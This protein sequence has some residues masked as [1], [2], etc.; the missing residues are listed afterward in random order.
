MEIMNRK[1]F[2]FLLIIGASC[3]DPYI[4]NL[5][6]IKP[7]LVVEGLITNENNSY[8]IKLSRTS[9]QRDSDPD[10]VADAAV[11]IIDEA[12]VKTNL[13]NCSDGYYKTDSTSFIGVIGKRYVL[14]IFTSDNKEYKSEE[15]TLYPVAKIDTLYYEKAEEAIGT[16]DLYSGIK[17]L[18]KSSDS[19][20]INNYF[21]WTFEE[22]WKTIMPGASRYT[23]ARINDTTFTFKAIPSGNEIC[24]KKN[25]SSSILVN[26][27]ISSGSKNIDRQ[28]IQ[29]IAPDLS[30]KLTQQYS[31][32]VKQYS[33]SEKEYNFWNNL[34]KVSE[35]NGDIFGS[36]PFAVTSNIYNVNDRSEM[37]FGYFEVLAVNQRR[38]NISAHDLDSLFLPQYRSN[39]VNVVISPSD[40]TG[41]IKPTWDG[42]YYMWMDTRLYTFIGP[43]VNDG[44]ILEGSVYQHDLIKFVFS[45]NACSICK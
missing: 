36:Q 5:K 4:P 9:R 2:F 45:R 27:I 30:D 44:V 43:I 8:K 35:T 26:S 24:W 38:L 42:L 13:Q 15:C 29:F 22:S 14:Q 19:N 23:Y 18:L 39:C 7:L 31:I 17:I 1:L 16:Y 25:K 32:L 28:E 3:I 6:N 41:P 12:G 34:K 40:Y 11:N 20:G 10:V 21:R 33:I 37:V